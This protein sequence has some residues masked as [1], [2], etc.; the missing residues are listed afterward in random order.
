MLERMAE[1]FENRI[2]TYDEHMRNDIESADEFYPFTAAQLPLTKGAEILD[3]GCGTGLEL[4]EYFHLNPV[5]RVT[6]VDLSKKMLDVLKGKFPDK[7]LKLVCGSYFDVPF[8]EN[9][10]DGAVSV[11]SLHHFTIEQK[12]P[13]YSKVRSALKNEGCF[14]LTDYFALTDEDEKTH[15]ETLKALKKEQGIEDD[16]FYHYDTPLTVEHEMQAL[17]EAGFSAVEIMKNWSATYTLKA[18]KELHAIDKTV[19]VTVDRQK[20]EC[21]PKYKDLVYP[22]NYGYVQGI[23]APDGK[24]QDA[25][26]LGVDESVREFSGKVIAVIKRL[27]DCEIKWVVAPDGISFTKDEISKQT[28]FVEKYFKSEILT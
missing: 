12:T 6:G 23:F 1:F 21:H 27:D 8:G 10:F 4:E 14:V 20:G 7:S 3:L 16:E 5:A 26:I 25:Y 24:E 2:D 9:A 19:N 28:Y 13:L 17:F 22:V 15:F 11:E 18:Y